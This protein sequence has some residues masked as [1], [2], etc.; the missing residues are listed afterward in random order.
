MKTLVD[1]IKGLAEDNFN[2]TLAIRRHLH[3]NPELSFLEFETSKY[4]QQ[5]LS[6]IGIPYETGFVKTGIVAHIKGNNSEKKVVALRA[7]MDALPIHENNNKSYCSVVPNV[8]H[9]CGHDVHTATLLGAAKIINELKDHFEGTVKLI[10]QPGEEKLPGG[11]KLMIEAGA[12]ENPKSQTII[13]QHVF[14]EL[15]AGKVGF[16]PGMYMAS[17][18]EIYVTVKGKGGHAALPHQIVDPILISAHLIT[19]LQQIVSRK[20]KPDV[21]SVLSFGKIIGNGATNVIPDI[22]QLEGTFRTMDENWRS[23]AHELMINMAEQIARSMGGDC[24]FRID[25]GYPFLIND[26]ELTHLIKNAAMEYLG[27]ENVV[28]LGLRMT[29]E[30]FAYYS[31]HMPACFY[32]LGVRNDKKGIVSNLHTSTFDIDES[33][34]EIGM[35]LMAYA[36]LKQLDTAN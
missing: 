32:R 16:K 33:S 10:F 34:L 36:A 26:E 24:E 21:P 30:D 28:E 1:K 31:Q 12:L 19:S 29:A 8:M 15:E 22:V 3:R 25:K 11:A 35:G 23:E 14:P 6:E 20:A 27:A 4:I 7:D 2:E 5:K 13:G 17:T 18:D 9:A